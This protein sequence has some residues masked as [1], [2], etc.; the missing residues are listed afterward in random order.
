MRRPLTPPAAMTT[1][2]DPA[3]LAQD[4]SRRAFLGLGAGLAALACSTTGA[5]TFAPATSCQSA[6]RSST[7]DSA[8][9][10]RSARTSTAN[11]RPAADRSRSSDRPSRPVAP[12]SN[13]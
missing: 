13:R 4:P 9:L 10:V 8:E 12:V 7:R 3:S 2:P 5:A 6:S 11:R 1:G